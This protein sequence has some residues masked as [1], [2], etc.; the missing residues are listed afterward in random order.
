MPSGSFLGP[1]CGLGLEILP[2]WLYGDFLGPFCGLSSEILLL[3]IRAREN[4]VK[5]RGKCSEAPQRE[6]GHVK[7]H[8]QNTSFARKQCKNRRKVF[9]ITTKGGEAPLKTRAKHE[10]LQFICVFT[11]CWPSGWRGVQRERGVGGFHRPRGDRVNPIPP[12]EGLR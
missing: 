11:R 8:E 7:K 5:T 3:G 9:R 12:E 4:T 10:F 1:F 2:K 6:A